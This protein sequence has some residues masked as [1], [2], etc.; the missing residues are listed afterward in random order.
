MHRQAITTR[1]IAPTNHR[2]ARIKA[3]AAAGSVI[4]SWDYAL[5]ADDNHRA[6]AKALAEKFGWGGTWFSGGLPDERGDVFV[7]TDALAPAFVVVSAN[8]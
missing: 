7:L 5:N 4:V 3:R 1:F 6:A 2:G 8:A